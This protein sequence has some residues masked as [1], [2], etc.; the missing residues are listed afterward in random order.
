MPAAIALQ[1]PA[2]LL[3]HLFY[4]IFFSCNKMK[5]AIK[6]D[7]AFILLQRLFY[8]IVPKLKPL[9]FTIRMTD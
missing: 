5:S 2:R 9:H 4:Y 1:E 6:Q 8:F 3:Q 7:K